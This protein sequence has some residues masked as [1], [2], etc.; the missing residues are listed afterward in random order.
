M[1][2]TYKHIQN[3]DQNALEPG[4]RVDE[5]RV[6]KERNEGRGESTAGLSRTLDQ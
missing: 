2:H 1:G 6:K 5:V 4:S 3:E